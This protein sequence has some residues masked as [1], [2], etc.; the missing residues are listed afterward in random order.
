M[1]AFSKA[2]SQFSK[3]FS[4]FL[5]LIVFVGQS[6]GITVPIRGFSKNPLSV[7][8]YSFYDSTEKVARTG[9]I[10]RK[11]SYTMYLAKNEREACQIAFRVR[12][13][14]NNVS[15]KLSDF[16]NENGDKLRSVLFEEYYVKTSGDTVNGLY[17]DALIPVGEDYVLDCMN[18]TNY[19]YYIS[20]RS[21]ED[22]PAGDYKGT[23]SFI[24]NDRPDNKYEN[25][26][27]EVKAHVWDF[28]LPE[29]PSMDTAM[30]LDKNC[31][32]SLHRVA[33]NSAQADELYKTYYEFL[34]DHGISPYNLPV[35]ILSSEADKY[36]SDPRCTSF[37]IPYGS[38]DYIRSVY[39]KLS[40]HPDWAAKA[41]FYPIDE[42]N[43]EEAY[44]RYYSITERLTRLYPG[45]HMVTPYCTSELEI[46]GEKRSATSLQKGYSDIMCPISHYFSGKAF[47]DECHKR[48]AEGDK[49]WWYVC[50]GPG[51]TTDYCNLFVQQEGIKHRLL[52]WQQKS[53]NITGL[54]YWS[55]NY[56][57][58]V[59]DPWNSAWTTP[60]TGVDTYGDGSLLYPGYNVNV[61]GPVSSLRLEAVANGIEDY[62]YLTMAQE[63]LG[64]KYVD[65]TIS[66]VSST[67]ER[68]TF[69]DSRFAS[70]RKG[71]GEAIEKAS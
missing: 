58:D 62:D 32:A 13:R 39:N 12:V 42:P 1:F 16:E 22:T 41:Y 15:I 37:C 28:T 27:I 68:Y 43:D 45:Y 56:W 34:L 6:I 64:E 60:W 59:K 20:V 4:A 40:A 35:D 46:G 50:C 18:E 69:S 31:I 24:W 2:Y 53:L 5:A 44:S 3:F 61:N 10:E 19:V 38:D 70:V 21:D 66:K 17:P 55:T 26:K 7:P 33:N 65:K 29:T 36:M 30:G 14:R 57:Y 25:L 47:V 23:V 71:L 9:G 67:L 54:L 11:S 48:Q 49:L 63:L 52:F 8:S 51:P